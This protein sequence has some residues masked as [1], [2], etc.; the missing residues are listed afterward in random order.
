MIKYDLHTHTSYCDG[1]D[2][3]QKMADEAVKKGFYALGFSGHAYTKVDE[4]CS[5]SIEGTKS[6]IEDI[7]KLKE[8]YCDKMRIF[9]A[10]EQDY[11]SIEPK[12][13]FDYMISSVHYIVKGANVYCVDESR[14]ALLRAIDEGYNGDAYA[15]AEDYY[16]LVSKVLKKTGGDVIGHFNLVEKF[17]Q[18]H[19]IFDPE[20]ERYV[21]AWRSAVDE[22]LKFKKPFEINVGAISRG[23]AKSPYPN[24]QMLKY[25]RQ[26]GG[27]VMYSGDTHDAK[28]LGFGMDIAENAAKEAGFGS[29][30]DE[31]PLNLENKNTG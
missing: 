20:N 7:L 28:F 13:D 5:M 6:Y 23:Y 16:S 14:Q 11:Y 19:K 31:L 21:S 18:D 12:Y 22:L 26:K 10:I 17:N 4:E 25:I 9:C 24:A 30:F 2:S 27:S 29:L 3:P 8:K 15:L 1:L